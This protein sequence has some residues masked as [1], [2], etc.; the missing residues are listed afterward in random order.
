M[1]TLA[2]LCNLHA[3]GPA[4]LQRLRRA[5]CESLAALRR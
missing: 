3:D 2:L 1:D 5:G 4:T